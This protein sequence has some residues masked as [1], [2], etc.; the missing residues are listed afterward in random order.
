[1]MTLFQFLKPSDSIHYHY[2][3]TS[4]NI[5]NA[6][7]PINSYTANQLIIMSLHIHCFICYS[8]DSVFETCNK[9]EITRFY[10]LNPIMEYRIHKYVI[11]LSIM[12]RQRTREVIYCIE[13]NTELGN[14][15]GV[16]AWR[17]EL[18]KTIITYHCLIGCVSGYL[19]YQ[20]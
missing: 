9:H 19:W 15:S 6:V 20:L 5:N 11:N 18:K 1:M 2:Y 3:C 14:L 12:I 7:H 16:L 4:W 10:L 8:I 17:W 13:K